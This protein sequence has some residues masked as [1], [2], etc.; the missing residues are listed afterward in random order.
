MGKHFL[1]IVFIA[2]LIF[3]SSCTKE[4]NTPS[5]VAIT[6]WEQVAPFKGKH[7]SDIAASGSSLFVI[8]AND[9]LCR[10]KDNETN[11]KTVNLKAH[12]FNPL[13]SV[14]DSIVVVTYPTI[15]LSKNNGDTWTDVTQGFIGK[16]RKLSVNTSAYHNTILFVGMEEDG[17]FSSTD[18]GV[19]W[20]SASRGLQSPMI[21]TMKTQGNTI[22]AGT[23]AATVDGVIKTGGLYKTTDNGQHW[24]STGL[25]S[26]TTSIY[27]FASSDNLL[28]AGTGGHGVFRST[29]NGANW[30]PVNSLLKNLFV[31]TLAISGNLIVAGTSSAGVFLSKDNGVTWETHNSGLLQ[32]DIDKLAV[33]NNILYAGTG[34]GLWKYMLP[35]LLL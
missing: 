6:A 12:S 33:H 11:W 1:F 28:I 22:Y 34:S 31:T 17:V 35:E 26:D 23:L 9:S 5:E 20:I 8:T 32:L 27:C 15:R 2:F 21:W 30:I 25:A 16:V 7:V 29:N 24:V 10:L 4:S 13:L 14:H 18:F 19:T 3:I